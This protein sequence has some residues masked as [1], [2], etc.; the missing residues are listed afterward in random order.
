VALN[1]I[2][3]T[4]IQITALGALSL[5]D[6][7]N[8]SRTLSFVCTRRDIRYTSSGFHPNILQEINGSFE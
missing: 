8:I 3:L 1:T 5:S 2:A 4:I 7:F 6:I